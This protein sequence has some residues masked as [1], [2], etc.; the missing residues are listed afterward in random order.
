MIYLNDWC[1]IQKEKDKAVVLVKAVKEDVLTVLNS[2]PNKIKQNL[3]NW[4]VNYKI[5]TDSI[6][7][8]DA[9]IIN[10]GVN[11][12]VLLEHGADKAEV[13]AEINNLLGRYF[14]VK[15]EIGESLNKMNIYKE[16]RKAR[17]VLDVKELKII[18]LTGPL[19]SITSFDVEQNT[20]SDGNVIKIP[21]NAIYEIKYFNTDI[22]GNAI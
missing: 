1:E 10:L 20:S 17:S 18:N 21:K 14:F 9:K 8:I 3:K 6:D 22:I 2:D 13:V 19:Y 12:T 5:A 15:S 16:I 11:Y 7:I 4:L